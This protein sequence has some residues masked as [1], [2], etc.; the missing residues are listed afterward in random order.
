MLDGAGGGSDGIAGG[1]DHSGA[2]H[3]R[4]Q[5]GD[6]AAASGSSTAAARELLIM[7]KS[8]DYDYF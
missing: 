1:S 7:I 2:L 3:S 6:G 4:T 8:H 5:G